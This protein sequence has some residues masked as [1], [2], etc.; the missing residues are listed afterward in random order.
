VPTAKPGCVRSGA[1]A[2]DGARDPEV[3]DERVPAREEDVLRL[4]VAVH[5]AALVRVRE[6]VG[7]L[8]RDAE[9]LRQRELRL[10]REVIAQRARF[11]EGGHV[12]EHAVRLPGVVHREDVRVRELRR[13]LDLAQE[14]LGGDRQAEVGAEDLER[15]RAP[16]P[17]VAGEEDDRHPAA[18]DLS[19]DLV[20]IAERLLQHAKE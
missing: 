10:A 16:V 20:S 3:G 14:A 12:V 11:D 2:A 17:E 6:R 18:S 8:A 15:D 5:H 9:R 4:D 13:D 19:F 7:D 1:S